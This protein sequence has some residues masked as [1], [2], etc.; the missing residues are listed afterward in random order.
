MARSVTGR[1]RGDLLGDVHSFMWKFPFLFKVGQH[2]NSMQSLKIGGHYFPYAWIIS[3]LILIGGSPYSFGAP[4]VISSAVKASIRSRVDNGYTPSIVI[5]M[6]NKDGRSFYGYGQT[7][8][9]SSRSPDEHTIYEIGSVSKILTTSLLADLWLNG[10]VD[11]DDFVEDYLPDEVSMPSRNNRRITLEHLATHYSGLPANPETL[12]GNDTTNP[13]V[14]FGV[15]LLYNYLNN[16]TLTRRPGVS[17]EYSNLGLGLLGH[18]LGISQNQS[19]EALLKERLL[20]PLGMSETMISWDV[21]KNEQRAIGYSGVVERPFFKMESLESAGAVLSNVHD[22]LT[23]AEY[24]IGLKES[25]L[26]DAFK[27]AHKKRVNTGQTGVDLGLGWFILSNVPSPILMH[28]GATMGHTAF[29]GM[30]IANQTAVVLFSNGRVNNYS[31]VQD[32]GI[33]VLFPQSPLRSIRRVPDVSV[34][35][36]QSIYGDF[37]SDTGSTVQIGLERNHLTVEFSEDSG[38]QYTLYPV[39][40]SRFMFYEATFEASANLRFDGQGKPFELTWRQNGESVTY[41]KVMRPAQLSLLA[42]DGNIHLDLVDGDGATDYEIQGTQDFQTWTSLGN[43]SLW[44]DPFKL[45]SD[46]PY[47][48]FQALASE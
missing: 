14:P 16:H 26:N 48:F 35:R 9:D 31:G 1:E 25:P 41:Q 38:T 12:A 30:D 34:D 46:L 3:A 42:G 10:E 47:Q 2:A 15:D 23:F 6:V 28:D 21:S 17:F 33:H 22:M 24:Q 37:Q 5:G 36:L 4:P 7:S 18:V 43:L 8:Y 45:D 32:I 11:L 44:D 13:F 40:S 27:E 29:L 20:N 19:F 39:S